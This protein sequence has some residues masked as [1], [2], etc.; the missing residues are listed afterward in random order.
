LASVGEPMK[1]TRALAV[2]ISVASSASASAGSVQVYAHRGARA[3]APE[4]TLPAY[5]T[6]LRIGADWVDM[7]VLLTKDG[8]V[9]IGHDPV[10]NPAIVREP[11][12]RFVQP[13]IVVKD[14]TLKEVQRYDVGRLD[15]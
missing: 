10:L 15:R 5:K 2:A 8:E 9:V 12:G 7:D 4:N 3:F 11:D 6:G 14:L 13:G 1:K